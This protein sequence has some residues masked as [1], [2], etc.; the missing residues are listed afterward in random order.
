MSEN[1]NLHPTK[2]NDQLIYDTTH[3]IMHGLKKEFQ[4]MLCIIYSMNGRENTAHSPSSNGLRLM[5]FKATFNNMS[6]LLWQSVL[7]VEKT[8]NPEKTT[9][10]RNSL[11]NFIT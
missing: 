9:E 1:M 10:L 8:E 4:F 7:L 6:G 3:S 2:Y 11:T 5:M